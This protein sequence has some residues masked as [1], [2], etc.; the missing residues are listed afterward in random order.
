M[1]QYLYEEA[2]VEPYA[3]RLRSREEVAR[4]MLRVWQMSEI[5]MFLSSYIVF[6]IL[7]RCSLRSNGLLGDDV[8]GYR[9]TRK[10]FL[11]PLVSTANCSSVISPRAYF[12]YHQYH[13]LP[14]RKPIVQRSARVNAMRLGCHSTMC[15]DSSCAIEPVAATTVQSRSCSTGWPSRRSRQI[16]DGR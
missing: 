2:G 13:C 10:P 7:A 15:V 8:T 5:A 3:P 11:A 12:R 9:S 1:L 14:Q 4:E 6:A 16:V